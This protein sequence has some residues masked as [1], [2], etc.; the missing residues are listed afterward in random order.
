MGGNKNTGNGPY[1][2]TSDAA[3]KLGKQSSDCVL[4]IILACNA[5]RCR[6]GKIVLELASDFV[7]GSSDRPTTL[8]GSLA[9]LSIHVLPNTHYSTKVEPDDGTKT[10]LA[11][12]R[13]Q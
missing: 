10:G 2:S 4:G 5:D 7:K 3:Q 1:F 9:L 6:C 8:V 11:L 13:R 12:A